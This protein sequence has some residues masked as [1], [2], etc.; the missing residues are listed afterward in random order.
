M[1]FF[2]SNYRPFEFP[3][4]IKKYL[5]LKPIATPSTNP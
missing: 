2:F 3:T 4:R 5:L 1:I